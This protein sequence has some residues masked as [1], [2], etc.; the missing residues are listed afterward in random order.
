MRLSITAM[1][2][3][4][5]IECQCDSCRDLESPLQHGSHRFNQSGG[6]LFIQLQ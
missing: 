4:P 5:S 3:L 1:P 2:P 6:K